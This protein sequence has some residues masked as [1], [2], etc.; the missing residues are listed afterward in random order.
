[1]HTSVFLIPFSSMLVSLLLVERF[2]NTVL[3]LFSYWNSPS[4]KMQAKQVMVS[5]TNMVGSVI[6]GGLQVVLRV[7]IYLLAWWFVFFILFIITSVVYITYEENNHVLVSF[8]LFY[9]ANVGPWLHY[10]LVIPVYLGNMIYKVLVPLWN[11]WIWF[12]KVFIAQAVLPMVMDEIVLFLKLVEALGGMIKNVLLSMVTYIQEFGCVDSACFQPGILTFNMMSPL[13]ELRQAIAVGVQVANKFCTLSAAPVDV[14]VYPWMDIN[15]AQFWHNLFNAFFQT[16]LVVPF[17]TALRCKMASDNSFKIMMC[18]PDV[19]PIF[20]S[21]AAAFTSLGSMLDN[22]IN[23]LLAIILEALTGWAPMCEPFTFGIV[24]DILNSQEIFGEHEVT[25]VGLTNWVYAITDGITIVY[26]G[27]T[28]NDTKF[29]TWP[30]PAVVEYGIAA[31]SY[32]TLNSVDVSVI[33][34]GATNIAL[35]TT[36]LMGCNCTDSTDGIQVFCFVAP[37]EGFVASNLLDYELSVIFPDKA[38]TENLYCANIDLYVRSVRWTFHRYTQVEVP[39]G[40]S[41]VNIPGG[42]CINSNT[43]RIVDATVWVVPRCGVNTGQTLAICLPSSSCYPYCMGTRLSGSV[44]NNIILGSAQ[45]WKRGRTLVDIDCNIHAGSSSAAHTTSQTFSTIVQGNVNVLQSNLIQSLYV[46]STDDPSNPVCYHRPNV[47]SRVENPQYSSSVYNTY[48]DTQPFVITGDVVFTPKPLGDEIYAVVIDRLEGDQVNSFS[49]HALSQEFPAEPPYNVPAQEF[50]FQNEEKILIPY[51]TRQARIAAV[52][53]KNYVFYASNPDYNVFSAYFDYCSRPP[54]QLGKFGL[55]ITSSYGP[56]RIYRVKAYTKCSTYSCG[57]GMIRSVD[58]DGFGQNYSKQCTGRLNVSISHL[59]YL[60]EDNIIVVVKEASTQN[61]SSETQTFSPTVTKIYWLN[62]AT[63]QISQHIWEAQLPPTSVGSLCPN[64]Q[65]LPRVGSFFMEIV[66]SAVYLLQYFVKVLIYLPGMGPIWQAGGRCPQ[67]SFGHHMLATCGADVFSLEDFFDSIA[68][69]QSIIWHTLSNIANLIQSEQPKEFNNPLVD[70]LNGMAMYGEGTTD[71]WAI[72][73]AVLTLAKIPIKEQLTQFWAVLQTG[74]IYTSMHQVQGNAIMW[75]RFGYRVGS[76]LVLVIIKSVLQKDYMT[77]SEIWRAIWSVLYDSKAY[78]TS[79]ITKTNQLA[80]SGIQLMLGVDNPWAEVAYYMCVASSFLVDNILDLVLKINIYIP[81]TVCICTKSRGQN[82]PS[83]VATEC[84]AIAPVGLQP[85]IY[86]LSRLMQYSAVTYCETILEYTRNKIIHSMDPW[87]SDMYSGLYALSEAIDFLL[88]VFDSDAGQCSN[89]A[90]DAHVVSIVPQPVD[91][92]QKC[93]GTSLCKTKCSSEWDAFQMY[94]SAPVSLPKIF[95]DQQSFFFPGQYDS[96]LIL[97]NATSIVEIIPAVS[98]CISRQYAQDFAIVVAEYKDKQIQTR[99]WCVPKIPSATVYIGSTLYLPTVSLPGDIMQSYFVASDGKLLALLLR[100]STVNHVYLVNDADGLV[101]LADFPTVTGATLVDVVDIW[102]ILGTVCSEVLYKTIVQELTSYNVVISKI[103]YC[104]EGNSWVRYPQI[105]FSQFAQNYLITQV[106]KGPVN[107][108]YRYLLLPK[109][110][111][112]PVY[113]VDIQWQEMGIAQMNIQIFAGFNNND[114]LPSFTN[115]FMSPYT[116]TRQYV[117][118]VNSQ[119]WNWLNKLTFN[120]DTGIPESFSGS[121]KVTMEVTPEGRCDEFACTGCPTLLA[122]RLCQA[123]S[124]CA[125]VRCIGTLVNEIRP[126]CALGLTLSSFGTQALEFYQGAWVILAEMLVLVLRLGLNPGNSL[127]IEWVEDVFMGYIC[128][129]KDFQTQFWSVLTSLLNMLVQT[130]SKQL[131][132][133]Y[134][135]GSQMNNNID[136]SST[137]QSTTFNAFLAQISYFPLY[138]MISMEKIYLCQINGML[139]ILDNTGYAVRIQSASLTEASDVVAGACLTLSSEVAQQYDYV[140]GG[141]TAVNTG[142]PGTSRSALNI[143]SAAAQ[144]IALQGMDPFIHLL[145]G[146]LTY[147]IGIIHT[148]AIWIMSFFQKECNPPDFFL[149]DMIHCACDDFELTIPI[150]KASLG[151]NDYAFWCTGTL[152]MVDSNN[153]Y[154][155]V[156]NPYTYE[157]LRQRAFDLQKHVECLSTSYDCPDVA[158]P[159]FEKQGVTLTNVLVKCRENYLAKQW[160]PMAYGIFDS[161][162]RRRIQQSGISFTLPTAYPYI[163]E[164]LTTSHQ[165]GAGPQACQEYYMQTLELRTTFEYWTYEQKSAGSTLGMSYTDSCLVFSGPGVVHRNPVFEA[166]V[167]GYN[168]DLIDPVTGQITQCTLNPSVWEVIS[169]NDIPVAEPHI[170]VYDKV[171]SDNIVKNYYQMAWKKVSDAFLE[172]IYVWQNASNPDVNVDFFSTEGDAIH[173]ILD[174]IYLG[175][176]S[177]INYWPI[178][179]PLPD[180]PETTLH[181]PSWSRDEND[182]VTRSID[183]NNCV[184]GESM[185]WS[186]GSSSR[187]SVIRYFVRNVIGKKQ[188][189]QQTLIQ[190]VVLAQLRDMYANWKS[191]DNFQCQ[192]ANSN[193]QGFQCCTSDSNGW[194]PDILRKEFHE[195][196]STHVLNSLEEEYEYLYNLTLQNPTPWIMYNS[197]ADTYDWSNSVRAQDEGIYNSNNPTTTYKDNLLTVNMAESGL[198]GL[199][200]GALKQVFFTIPV[201]GTQL[202]YLTQVQLYDG[203]PDSLNKT[204]R[205][206]IDTAWLHSPTYRYYHPRY[207]PSD[208]LMCKQDAPAVT[209]GTSNFNAFS[210]N[211]MNILQSS[212]VLASNSMSTGNY[213]QYALGHIT[214]FCG[215]NIVVDVNGKS[216]CQVPTTLTTCTQVCQ[217]VTCTGTCLYPIE[218]NHLLM[219]NYSFMATGWTCPWHQMSP[220]WGFLDDS[221][222]QT[223]MSGVNSLTL[224]TRDLLQYGRSGLR[225]GNVLDVRLHTSTYINPSQRVIPTSH[226]T[227]T[228]CDY[229]ERLQLLDPL[230]LMEELFPMVQGIEEGGVAS[231]CLRY[232]IEKARFS[233]LELAWDLNVAVNTEGYIKQRELTF[234]WG[235]KCGTQLNLLHL[236]VSLDIFHGPMPSNIDAQKCQYLVPVYGPS[237]YTTANCLVFL[238]DVFYDPCR[239]MSCV[240]TNPWMVDPYYLQTHPECKLRF[241]PRH[242]ATNLYAP[243]GAWEGETS[244]YMQ[245]LNFSLLNELL[246]DG[247]AV[248]NTP[249]G[250]SW[251][252]TEG[253]ME[254]QCESCDMQVDYWPDDWDYPVGYHVSTTCDSDDMSYRSFMNVF[255]EDKDTQKNK[256]LLYQNDV[257]RNAQDIDA[258]FGVGGFCRQNNFGMSLVNLNSIVYCVRVKLDE[259]VDVTIPNWQSQSGTYS[260]EKCATSSSDLPWDVLNSESIVYQSFRVSL[261]TVPNM[262]SVGATTYPESLDQDMMDVASI[263]ISEPG[264]TPDCKDYLIKHCDNSV[265]LCNVGFACRGKRC[266][267]TIGY[268][269]CTTDSDCAEVGGP[270]QGLCVKEDVQCLRHSDCRDNPSYADYMCDGIG[271]CVPPSIKVYNPNATANFSVQFQINGNFSSVLG[272][273]YSMTGAS[274]WGWMGRDLLSMHGMCSYENWYK[275]K[276]YYLS[277]CISNLNSADDGSAVCWLD[278][279]KT[280]Y[281]DLSVPPTEN[282]QTWWNANNSQPYVMGVRPTVCDRDYERLQGFE[283]IQPRPINFYVYNGVQVYSFYDVHEM[284]D[285][286][287]RAYDR[288]A[289]GYKVAMYR[290]DAV[291]PNN[292]I[293]GSVMADFIKDP[294]NNPLQKCNQFRQCV[295]SPFTRNFTKATR[296]VDGTTY[297]KQNTYI[298]GAIG[299]LGTDK[300]CH[301]DTGVFPLYNFLCTGRY[302]QDRQVCANNYLDVFRIDACK[303]VMV[304]YEPKYSVILQNTQALVALFYLLQNPLATELDVMSMTDCAEGFYKHI[305]TSGLYYTNTLYYPLAFVLK[306]FPFDW[307]YQCILLN[308]TPLLN[309]NMDITQDCPMYKS[310]IYANPE[311][312]DKDINYVEYLRYARKGMSLKEFNQFQ[313][314]QYNIGVQV[315]QIAVGHLLDLY[316]GRADISYPICSA[317]RS[318]LNNLNLHANTVIFDFYNVSYCEAN[319]QQRL[320]SVIN[321]KGFHREFDNPSELTDLLK[322]GLGTPDLYTADTY[323][324][325]ATVTTL[326]WRLLFS[327]N[328]QGEVDVPNLQWWT[329]QTKEAQNTVLDI[330]QEIIKSA[331]KIESS[332]NAIGYYVDFTIVN[333]NLDFKIADPALYPDVS[334]VTTITT[335][336]FPEDA[337]K[338]CAFSRPNDCVYDGFI[339]KCGG[340]P[341]DAQTPAFSHIGKFFCHYHYLDQLGRFCSFLD[342]SNPNRVY[343]CM[344][345]FINKIFQENQPTRTLFTPRNLQFFDE[346]E[347][348]QNFR[349]SFAAENAYTRNNQPDTT[350]TVMCAVT[351]VLNIDFAKCNHPFWFTLKAHVEKYYTHKGGVVVPALNQLDWRVG[352]E[353]FYKG[354]LTSYSSM[355]R[356]N[357]EVYLKKLFD[358]KRVCA[359]S[360][361]DWQDKVCYKYNDPAEHIGVVNPW[362]HGYYNPYERCDVTFGQLERAQDEFIDTY[363]YTANGDNTYPPDMP[364]GQQCYTRYG[365]KV[366][367]LGPSRFTVNPEENSGNDFAYNLCAHTLTQES[368]CTHDQGILGG[369]NGMFVGAP[370]YDYNMYKASKY[371]AEQA[372][373]KVAPDM[374]SKSYIPIPDDFR[375]GLFAGTNPLWQGVMAPTGFLQVPDYELGIHNI[376]MI[377]LPPNTSANVL[378]TLL[379]VQKLPLVTLQ[380]EANLLISQ[381]QSK[382]VLD[383]VPN[384][385]SDLQSD[386]SMNRNLMGGSIA[387][388]NEEVLSY[389][390]PL[391]RFAHYGG[392]RSSFRPSSP[393]PIRSNFFFARINQDTYAH[394]TMTHVQDGR[395]FGSYQTVNGF[396][397]CPVV[398]GIPQRQCQVPISVST[399]CSLDYTVNS[400]KAISGLWYTSY[401]F[402]ANDKFNNPRACTMQIDWPF[403]TNP[404]RDGSKLTDEWDSIWQ[405]SASDPINK[406][407]HVLD[408]LAPFQYRYKN[409]KQVQ[410]DPVRNTINAGVC[411]TGRVSISTTIPLSV[412]GRCVLSS[413]QSN[414]SSHICDSMSASSTAPNTFDLYRHPKKNASEMYSKFKNVKRSKCNQCSAP[415]R[416]ATGAD[417]QTIASESSFGKAYKLSASRV[418][419]HDLRETLTKNGLANIINEPFWQSN[420][421]LSTYLTNPRYLITNVVNTNTKTLFPED[422][423]SS[424]TLDD[425]ERWKKPWVFCPSA[426]ALKNRECKGYIEREDWQKDKIHLCPKVVK[427]YLQDANQDPMSTVS[428]ANIDKHTNKVALA[429]ASA[430][431]III[432][433]NCIASGALYCLPQPFVYHP[434]TYETTNK[435][436]V[437][438]TVVQYYTSINSTSCP[439]STNYEAFLSYTANQQVSCPANN[440]FLFEGFLY[441]I[442][443][444]VRDVALLLSSLFSLAIKLLAAS[445]SKSARESLRAEWAGIRNTASG[446]WDNISDMLVSMFMNSGVLGKKLMSFISSACFIMNDVTTF[447]ATFLC[448]FVV[449]YVTDAFGYLR[450]F[451]GASSVGLQ[452]IQGFILGLL[453]DILPLSFLTKYVSTGVGNLLASKFSEP[454]DKSNRQQQNNKIVNTNPKSRVGT[455]TVQGNLLKNTQ[456]I[457]GAK[458]GTTFLGALGGTVATAVVFTGIQMLL[459]YGFDTWDQQMKDSLIPQLWPSDLSMFDFQDVI[460]VMDNVVYYITN[461]DKCDAYM[462]A[463]ESE[464]FKGL[465]TCPTFAIDPVE[466]TNPSKSIAAS[467]CWANAQ[468]SLGQSSAYSCS[469]SSTC[470]PAEGCSSDK[471]NLLLCNNCPVPLDDTSHFACQNMVCQCGVPIQVISH[472]AS[473]SMCLESN[474][475]CDLILS[476]QSPSYGTIECSVCPGKVICLSTFAGQ[477]SSCACLMDSTTTIDT[478]KEQPG[479]ITYPDPHKLCGYLNRLTST[480][481][482]NIFSFTDITLVQCKYSLQTKC[483]SVY[484]SSGVAVNMPM[485]Y[486]IRLQTGRRLFAMDSLNQTGNTTYWTPL[487]TPYEYENDYDKLTDDEVHEIMRLPKWNQSAMPCNLLAFAFQHNQTLSVLEE[488]ELKKCA[489]WRYMGTRMIYK[490]NL[491]TLKRFPTFLVSL[492]DFSVALTQKD[493]LV[494][495]LNTPA[496]FSQILL[497]HPYMKPLRAMVIAVANTIDQVMDELIKLNMTTNKVKSEVDEA[498]SSVEN[499]LQIPKPKPKVIQYKNATRKRKGR[500]LLTTLSEIQAVQAYSAQI[501]QGVQNPPVSLVL[502]QSWVRGPY[503]WPPH[504]EYR[505]LDCTILSVTWSA[506]K[507][508]VVVVSNYYIHINDPIPPMDRTLKG[509]LPFFNLPANLSQYAP[510]RIGKSV[511]STVVNSALKVTQIN[512]NTIIHFLEG[513]HKWSFQWLVQ[514]AIMCDFASLMSCSRHNYDLFAS[515]G[516]FIILYFV[517]YF[518]ASALGFPS[519]ATLYLITIPVW[520]LWYVY[521]VSPN[522]LPMLPPCLLDDVQMLVANTFPPQFSYPAELYCDNNADNYFPNVSQ[523]KV[524]LKSCEELGFTDVQDA[525]VY[526]ICWFDN[527]T[528]SYL[529]NTT[530]PFSIAISNSFERFTGNVNHAHTFCWMIQSINMIPFLL[531]LLIVISGVSAVLYMLISLIPASLQLL[532]QMLAFTHTE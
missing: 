341:C 183:I 34:D 444:V 335:S 433:A 152:G 59:E 115:T 274:Y 191:I 206:I 157:Q 344:H 378:V 287:T 33:S 122:Q 315:L 160:D 466:S 164:C 171:H 240:Q 318:W 266:M 93:S 202:A 16:I 308:P 323:T 300:Q 45:Q 522:C 365:Q 482:D 305:K 414:I 185:P 21:L 507:E 77:T 279:Y 301:L 514:S 469:A 397:F 285:K 471:S 83:F 84:A 503:S 468:V 133:K 167:D 262:P 239:C 41:T 75:A 230:Q 252:N 60:N 392:N 435:E 26:K 458:K 412:T 460:D 52:A 292:F 519:L 143:V 11:T 201:D 509:N 124:K 176:Y 291:D 24:E 91:Y 451:A 79:T 130:I 324:L 166:C 214:C 168:T 62:P 505:I 441:I 244:D 104:W 245:Y 108:V 481:S 123:Y 483:A 89:F 47:M 361:Y 461:N 217:L 326:N 58:L 98:P 430:R 357:Q 289:D 527:A 473:N 271:K 205:E 440:F 467:L 368:D 4:K 128:S 196:N 400:L 362:L 404:L 343:Y 154:F 370:N 531:L 86:M 238:N 420:M 379:L 511:A 311:N 110:P 27:Q 456:A 242:K 118:L 17:Q 288:N 299:Y 347:W 172:A 298:C 489:Y 321:S 360:A 463:S 153:N 313:T 524:C 521:G 220:S 502:S 101:T 258:Y 377:L 373:Y 76:N 302:Q 408:R 290:F 216:L 447:I 331:W 20:N 64:M 432:T 131:I 259:Q 470:C 66:N 272:D 264:W 342:I 487:S 334:F 448:K 14:I 246:Q 233:V 316:P 457:N 188:L 10:F 340:I 1:M 209:Y 294:T 13:G 382:D 116:L 525:M 532:S 207:V 330:T 518:F 375:Q 193:V 411:K 222:M 312:I 449:Q 65:K 127:N 520:V 72:R 320:L 137:I 18:T 393:S 506:L 99:V 88:I 96:N 356:D 384:L 180:S 69:A 212:E 317:Y 504:Y 208:S 263:A 421:F 9:N 175:P 117:L 437:H 203:N 453:K 517:I 174:C 225:I 221:T 181:G 314:A 339:W 119:G 346:T 277:S 529:I 37:M 434:A 351:N 250:M 276:E 229:H 173:Q 100:V 332:G 254:S 530:K 5:Q 261:G 223:W 241:D 493:V 436:W 293:Y 478:C 418:L 498:I 204:I 51:S 398:P 337:P 510:D 381:Y 145:D 28:S 443:Q 57:A 63:M 68:D 383:W 126:L 462:A 29:G 450:K 111:L 50:T 189:G 135:S 499:E 82:L 413:R 150:E 213:N 243:I 446:F 70:I 306:E 224:S 295:D 31:V 136:A 141:T 8:M 345:K 85:E 30:G 353:M 516:F 270:C 109:D 139:A 155:T 396:C 490:Y 422:N 528:C 12:Q 42:D 428:F 186:C 338:R 310:S 329:T 409:S 474:S 32:S 114:V 501:L 210:Q 307:Y 92:F 508:I 22:W 480:S 394:P 260:A 419:A 120:L 459:D 268:H 372:A 236:C 424:W 286:F 491:T 36:A 410:V 278:P 281:Y 67:N 265:N 257:M 485:S 148:F 147:Y 232:L 159:E 78:Y 90:G 336:K 15:F 515:I 178:P 284:Y 103:H 247:D 423:I 194:L 95:V 3:V 267:G 80:C 73:K 190:K 472:C 25:V 403:L 140:T 275:Y 6:A 125:L 390:C 162:V 38:V 445:F 389:Q 182:G 228:S 200:H 354:F 479:V 219:V 464:N 198:W 249:V 144:Y 328:F 106:G 55:L 199:C 54:D 129:A 429:I 427:T 405:S 237:F 475:Q 304:R 417:K 366:T 325:K 452:I 369:D 283:Y 454:S 309:E 215:W 327:T 226:G 97:N 415:P 251:Q 170:V 297:D 187:Q 425:R 497:T 235:R 211:G 280:K 399:T 234:L 495:L 142:A 87:F 105:D 156:F 44:N 322:L 348:Q 406:K 112:R 407:C 218:S 352:A 500:K 333:P 465:I 303:K 359:G 169:K 35:Q 146:Y 192:C 512:F 476:L 496:M 163:A 380:K 391:R 158:V 513:Q 165:Q 395:F 56:I 43:C 74:S 197:K 523:S 416:F 107:S 256:I 253:Y 113:Y 179:K 61:Y 358:E 488:F 184:S 387:H 388:V 296:T 227:I 138:S 255:T 438:N 363:I 121:T 134:S 151:L 367:T 376:G 195:V 492:D 374:Y 48:F 248:G 401:V 484:M 102:P 526:S 455:G 23:V 94:K 269:A 273:T 149:Q 46:T 349:F 442:R 494:Q 355:T 7:W 386:H 49:M 477:S 439:V 39:F 364:L 231:V 486:S 71:L 19:T 371:T 81:V 282:A 319:W 402:I 53:S 431:E 385:L 177:R 161:S 132:R 2:V 426:T 40:S 350:K